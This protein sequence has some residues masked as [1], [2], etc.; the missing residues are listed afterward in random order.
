[1]VWIQAGQNGRALKGKNK[2]DRRF[3]ELLGRLEDFLEAWI[4][5]KE[6]LKVV[7][8]EK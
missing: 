3:E 8:N 6:I 1:M 4:F 5:L 2:E 7:G